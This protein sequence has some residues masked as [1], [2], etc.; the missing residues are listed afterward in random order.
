MRERALLEEDVR[1]VDEH[2]RA[3]RGRDAQD[4]GERAV[5]ARRGRAEVGCADDVEGFCVGEGG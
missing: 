1:L 3:P 4:G 2:D 5:D